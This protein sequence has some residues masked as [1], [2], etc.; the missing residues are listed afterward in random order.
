MLMKYFSKGYQV[1]NQFARHYQ[2]G[3]PLPKN[4]KSHLCEKGLCCSQYATSGLLCHSA[5]A[6][7][8]EAS[9]RQPTSEIPMD[10]QGQVYS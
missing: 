8:W 7:E 5:S 2:T 9:L 3:Q 10:T 1:V 6:P 4:M